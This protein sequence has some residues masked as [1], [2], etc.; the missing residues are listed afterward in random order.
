[1]LQLQGLPP[2][3]LERNTIAPQIKVLDQPFNVETASPP[4]SN[5]NSGKFENIA[6]FS[7][8]KAR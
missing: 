8:I 5:K 2:Y 4:L 6:K 1:L 3:S 7:M